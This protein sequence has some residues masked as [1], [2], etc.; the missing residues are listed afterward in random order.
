M[1]NNFDDVA[2]QPGEDGEFKNQFREFLQKNMRI[3]EPVK[4]DKKPVKKKK[5]TTTTKFFA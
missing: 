1:D 2:L 3:E 5:K 4:K